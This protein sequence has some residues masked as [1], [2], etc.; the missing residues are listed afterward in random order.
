MPV[1]G[2]S[3]PTAPPRAPATPDAPSPDAASPATTDAAGADAA[4][5]FDGAG[6]TAAP[7]APT[8]NAAGTDSISAR[9]DDAD[10]RAFTADGEAKWKTPPPGVDVVENDGGRGAWIEKWRSPTTGKWV[11]N[12][13]Q[14]YMDARADKK[15]VENKKFAKVVTDIRK[16]VT[17][18]LGRDGSKAQQ[19]ALVV[20]LMD[21]A[22]FRVGNEESDDNGVYGVTTLLKRHVDIGA[23]GQIEF[24]YVGKK[25]V[26]QHRVVVDKKLAKILKRLHAR[27]GADDARLFE[28]QGNVIDAGDVNDWLE[29]F[30][31]TAKMF[32]TFHATRLMREALGQHAGAPKAEREALVAA[33]FEDTAALLGHTPAVCRS[34]Y[35]DPT[36]IEEFT[37][38]G[39]V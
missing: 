2:P 28:H 9:V 24:R 18:D 31:V 27:A 13:T 14:A 29:P 34:S 38:K 17:K 20:A 22:Y 35:V 25:S 32:R 36:V 6:G 39:T 11:H 3:G 10:S 4:A 1:R 15:F 30:D 37:R 12:Y 26:E 21:Q 19:C 16:K 7:P 23:D 33:A 5:T 8:T